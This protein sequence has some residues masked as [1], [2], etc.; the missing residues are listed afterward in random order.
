MLISL[1]GFIIVLGLVYWLVSLIP[2]PAP[3]PTIVKV[4]F[5]I[6]AVLYILHAFGVLNTGITI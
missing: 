1:I 2:L 6:I 4:L 3:F 5:I